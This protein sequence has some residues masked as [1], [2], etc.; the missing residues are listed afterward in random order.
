MKT[1]SECILQQKNI[2]WL[3]LWSNWF[4][5]WSCKNAIN[6]NDF[7]Q[8]YVQYLK[9]SKLIDS[10]IQWHSKTGVTCINLMLRNNSIKIVSL[11]NQHHNTTYN[12]TWCSADCAIPAQWL[13]KFRQKHK[14][15]QDYSHYL[16]RPHLAP[17]EK[18]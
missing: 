14:T 2:C 4:R 13:N 6:F 5:K 1:F 18:K 15:Y 10:S 16:M 11:F 17:A 3:N 12:I 7:G 8:L 9:Q